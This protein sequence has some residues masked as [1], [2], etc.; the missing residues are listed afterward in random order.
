MG[1]LSLI[2][3]GGRRVV[4][5]KAHCLGNERVVALAVDLAVELEDNVKL[6]HEGVHDVR[7]LGEHRHVAH[8]EAVGKRLAVED[9]VEPRVADPVGAAR[10]ARQ[11]CT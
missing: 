10:E 4:D 11:K 1:G 6:L 8:K 7:D 2:R 9:A 3:S 5:G